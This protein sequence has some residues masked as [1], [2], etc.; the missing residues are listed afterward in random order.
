MR[1]WSGLILRDAAFHAALRMRIESMRP[2]GKVFHVK[3]VPLIV[4]FDPFAVAS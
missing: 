1:P 2:G 3:H 4:F